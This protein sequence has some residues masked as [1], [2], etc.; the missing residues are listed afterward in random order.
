[1]SLSFCMITTFYPPYSF[2]GDAIYLYNL[3][4]LLTREGHQV[5]V[6]HC[7]DSYQL[8]KAQPES[9]YY[10]LQPAVRI[11]TLRSGFGALSP[12]LSH[13]T[14][15]P[16]LKK[17]RILEIF[18]SRRF[19]VI[20]YHNASL[21][22][23]GVFSLKPNYSGCIKL[24]TAHE[25]WLVCPMNVLWK[26]TGQACDKPECFRCTVAS[27]RPPQLWRYTRLRDRS[28]QAIDLFLSP[29]RFSARMHQERGFPFPIRHLPYFTRRRDHDWQVPGQSPSQRPYFLFAGRLEQIKGL[30]NVL[31]EFSGEGAY[32]LLVVGAGTYEEK[33]REQAR[34]MSR[35]KFVGWVSQE[36]IGRYYTNALGVIVPSI[37][38]ETFGLPTIEAFARKRPVVVNRLGP[39]PEIVEESGGGY[40]YDSPRQL[41][42]IMDQLAKN[43]RLSDELGQRGYEAFLKFWTPDRHLE[44]YLELIEDL[45]QRRGLTPGVRDALAI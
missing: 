32:D 5:E 15:Y 35:V 39:L 26:Y 41:R 40:V 36:Q 6:I 24:Y 9:S 44:M 29:S 4:D 42:A 27:R 25:H 12:L 8:Y 14:G 21:F 33:L 45:R 22:G 17:K 30:Q 31:P 28:A 10:E 2:G 1:M 43:P 19:D 37:T 20:H 23:P 13:Q 7:A 16:F 3:C 18:A 11:H 38:Y 34:V